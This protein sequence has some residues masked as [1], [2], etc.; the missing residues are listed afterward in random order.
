MKQ[1]KLFLLALVAIV[2]LLVLSACGGGATEAPADEHTDNDEHASETAAMPM[3][4][5]HEHA[6]APDEFASLTN[7]FAGDAAAAD[8]GKAIFETNCVVCHGTEGHGDGPSAEALD[9][10]P[11]DLS[12]S[13]MMSSM[14]D[15]YLYW[16]VTEGGVIEPFNS[17]MPPW[18][19]VLN[20][21]QTW[22]VITYIR[23]LSQ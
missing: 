18:K 6:M 15:G 8:A 23:T 7:P 5:E 11:A 20:E 10:K 1:K 14:A 12:D 9:P 2:A 4:N 21:D 19:A 13:A 22:Q 17:A 3:E 16:R